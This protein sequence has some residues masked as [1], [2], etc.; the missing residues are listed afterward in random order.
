MEL[1]DS[2][3]IP[4]TITAYARDETIFTPGDACDHVLYIKAGGVKLSVVSRTGEEA[5]VAV[6]GRGDFFGEGC[7]AGHPIRIGSATAVTPTLILSIDK[8]RMARLLH[9]RRALSHRF[10]AHLLARHLSITQDLIQL[11]DDWAPST[12]TAAGRPR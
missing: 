6:L 1:L 4:K 5:V 9:D 7:L 8:A 10:I 3:G 12:M 2:A 11:L